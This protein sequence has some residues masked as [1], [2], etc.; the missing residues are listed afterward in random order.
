[1]N[2]HIAT[3]HQ[4]DN[5]GYVVLIGISQDRT[6]VFPTYDGFR[7]WLN[8]YIDDFCLPAADDAKQQS[9]EARKEAITA[10]HA[11]Q[12]EGKTEH[13][14][15]FDITIFAANTAQTHDIRVALHR[16]FPGL[17]VRTRAV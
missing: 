6:L 12:Y 17:V 1:M 16:I 7:S 13:R 3:I 14:Q 9:I 8:Y 5:G 10:K 4:S 2:R 15:Q 11:T